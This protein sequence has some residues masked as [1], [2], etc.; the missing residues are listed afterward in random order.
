MDSGH[1]PT[2]IRMSGAALDEA[3]FPATCARNTEHRGSPRP[4]AP[5]F[6]KNSASS[7]SGPTACS[8][9]TS[10]ATTPRFAPQPGRSPRA[11]RNAH[12][13]RQLG[14]RAR[15]SGDASTDVAPRARRRPPPLAAGRM[16][17]ADL[18][19]LTL[20]A[21][22]GGQKSAH[23]VSTSGSSEE[24]RTGA[25]LSQAKRPTWRTLGDVGRKAKGLKS[26]FSAARARLNGSMLQSSR[27]AP[28]RMSVVGPE[29]AWA[30]Q[31]ARGRASEARRTE[32]LGQLRREHL[33]ALGEAHA[34]L[35]QVDH[36]RDGLAAEALDAEGLP[37]RG[38]PRPGAQK[39]TRSLDV[40][41]T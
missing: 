33:G 29:P 15:R 24:Q 27:R 35:D 26:P 19:S 37:R 4:C 22:P 14:A 10:S 20:A 2:T 1:I 34:V 17:A 12:R 9:A 31:S 41:V 8:P 3:P 5:G 7:N 38:A 11:E 36:L 28:D 32:V 30:D 23:P 6:G 16:A 13:A 39:T 25:D 18:R 40:A 21:P